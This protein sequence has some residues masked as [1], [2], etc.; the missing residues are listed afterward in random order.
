[1]VGGAATVDDVVEGTLVGVTAPVGPTEAVLGVVDAGGPAAEVDVHDVSAPNTNAT[2]AH[3]PRPHN[4]RGSR[5][6]RLSTTVTC[7]TKI[8]ACSPSDR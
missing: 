6:A 5:T 1:V 3:N 8:I 2:H 7:C 4:P